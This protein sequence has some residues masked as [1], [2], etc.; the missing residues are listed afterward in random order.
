M[1]RIVV[2]IDA[3]NVLAMGYEQELMQALTELTTGARAVGIHVIIATNRPTSDII[4]SAM[5]SHIPTRISFAMPERIDS[6]IILDENGAEELIGPGDMIFKDKRWFVRIQCAY[7]DTFE[8]QHIAAYIAG[9]QGYNAPFSLPSTPMEDPNESAGVDMNYLDP[10]FA[11]AARL[12]ISTQQGSTS[13]IQRKFSIGYNRAERLINQLEK[14][15]V[16][17]AAHGSRSREVLILDDN[18]LENLLNSLL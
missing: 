12:I 17:G 4:S 11:D 5:K 14:A 3:Y 10:L 18:S 6:Q 15:G 1:P 13:M 16:V 9:Q 7:V 8:T 2:A